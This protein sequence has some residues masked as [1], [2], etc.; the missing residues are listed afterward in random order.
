MICGQSTDTMKAKDFASIILVLAAI[1][2]GIIW[3]TT[4]NPHWV[5]AYPGGRVL[6]QIEVPGGCAEHVVTS[7]DSPADVYAY[8]RSSHLASGWSIDSEYIWSGVE[9][10]TTF[11]RYGFEAELSVKPIASG[12]ARASIFGRR[13]GQHDLCRRGVPLP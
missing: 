3:A 8:Y 12:L 5:A 6:S 13:A 10:R 9:Q 7:Q 4:P 11:V 2:L 1:V